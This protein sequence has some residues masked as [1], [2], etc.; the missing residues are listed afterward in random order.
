[1]RCTSNP[2]LLVIELNSSRPLW[3]GDWCS[4]DIPRWS[5]PPVITHSGGKEHVCT[6]A[7]GAQS[8]ITANKY[9][10]QISV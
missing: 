10:L 7:L 5:K 4:Y 8:C 9:N 3:E 2:P 1:M 6:V